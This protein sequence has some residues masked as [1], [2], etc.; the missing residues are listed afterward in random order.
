V[1]HEDGDVAHQAHA[2]LVGV[3]LER[4]P[5]VEKEELQEPWHRLDR[6]GVGPGGRRQ[7]FRLAER[8]RR[9]PFGP[10]TQAVGLLA[11]DKE[12]EVLQP[13]RVGV[14]EA[15]EIRLLEGGGAPGELVR[16]HLQ[17]ARARR[18]HRAV[19]DPILRKSREI[20]Q[21]LR[22]QVPVRHQ[23]LQAD[24]HGV[25]GEGRERL[26]GR[27]AVAG[28]PE[29]QHLPQPHAHLAQPVRELPRLHADLPDA[30]RPGKTGRM[31]KNARLAFEF[32]GKRTPFVLEAPDHR[33]RRRRCK[34]GFAGKTRAMEAAAA[35]KK[36]P[37]PQPPRPGFILR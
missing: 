2:V 11:G 13:V 33:H 12:G 21:I 30:I 37:Q 23:L 29:R 18:D 7:G 32:H 26:V 34:S 15:L 5:L 4:R 36:C 16:G 19:V 31:K 1:G 6:G 35:V 25:A 14:A 9:R 20:G 8:Q 17:H 22:R 27:I 28:R 24:Q 3:R 10:R